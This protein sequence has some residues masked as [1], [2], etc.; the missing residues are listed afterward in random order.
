[1]TATSTRPRVAIA[2]DYLTQRGG[3]ERVVLAMLRAFPDATIHTTLYNPE[4]TFPEFRDARIVTTGLDRVGALRRHHRV[5]LPFLAPA[6]NLHTIDADVVL[7]SSSGWSHGFATTGKRLVYCYS[8]ARWLYQTDTYLGAPARSTPTGW[9]TLAMRPALRRWDLRMARRADRYLAISHVVRYRIRETYGI[10]ADVVPAPHRGL[11][12]GFREPL[13]ELAD[14]ADDGYHVLV[15]RLLPYKN[16]GACVEAFRGL[17]DERLVIVGVGPLEPEIRAA[18]PPNARLVSDLHD[19][20]LQ[21]VYAHAS[22][23]IAPSIEDFGLTPL[24]AGAH[25]VPT[26]ALR[27]GGY[28]DTVVEGETGAFFDTPTPAAITAAVRARAARAWDPDLIRAQ[29]DR[30]TE[31]RFS[32]ALHR[33]VDELLA[34]S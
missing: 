30:F 9:A 3:A 32:A 5:A 8:P 4:R 6:V 33:Y 29:A 19:A 12:G 22:T 25:G 15:S 20:Q 7:M 21:W 27:G 28:L 18:L 13:D 16:V 17:P 26:L 14:W 2:H 11:P 24:E 23:L 31:A 1:M 10:D 34:D